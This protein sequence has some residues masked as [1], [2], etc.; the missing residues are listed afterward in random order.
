[1]KKEIEKIIDSLD[2]APQERP[3]AID[4]LS[5]LFANR[6]NE[7]CS[8]EEDSIPVSWIQEIIYDLQ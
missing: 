1:M 5:S 6:L 7:L 8:G 4:R 3:W 2:M